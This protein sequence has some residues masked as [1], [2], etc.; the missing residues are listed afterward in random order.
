[1]KSDRTIQNRLFDLGW[2]IFLVMQLITLTAWYALNESQIKVYVYKG[3]TLLSCALFAA[4]IIINL[5]KK[6]YP[7]KTFICYAVFGVICALSWYFN[8][9]TLIILTF[10]VFMAVYEIS[11][12]RIIAIAAFISGVM[13]LVTV[14]MAELGLTTNYLFDAEA[15]RP[16]YGLGFSWATNAPTILTFFILQYIYLRKDRMRVWEYV[17][18]EAANVY[19]YLRTDTNL[20][21][22][23]MSAVLVLFFIEGL[24]KNHWRALKHLKWLYYLMPVIVCAVTM[25]LYFLWMDDN[26]LWNKFWLSLNRLINNR[27]AYGRQAIARFGLTIF[28]Q[29]IEWVGGTITGQAG[30]YNYVDCSYIQM[31][32]E[33]G[34]AFLAAAICVYTRMIVRAVKSRDFWLV[35]IAIIILV[36]SFT[37]PR[38]MDLSF[39]VIP[40]LAFARLG[41]EK[42]EY[43]GSSLKKIFTGEG[44]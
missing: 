1:M 31:L 35:F 34:I 8:R 17:I 14:T 3:V 16:R 41:E 40:V 44:K 9:N 38:M 6:V 29:P 27:M 36:H 30:E 12:R 13:L 22:Y 15:G 42:L 32:L 4:V 5:I 26:E 23:L 25:V 24:F 43:T 11:G 28:G 33:R 18:L 37:E 7:L 39:N 2:I 19:M 20:P 21:F 10:L